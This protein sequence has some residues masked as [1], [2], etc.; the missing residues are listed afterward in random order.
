M[1]VA[2][3]TALHPMALL[4]TCTPLR[5]NT[6]PHAVTIPASLR[7]PV[8]QSGQE[9]TVCGAQLD[10]LIAGCSAQEQLFALVE[11]HGRTFSLTQSVQALSLAAKLPL[12]TPMCISTQTGVVQL[13]RLVWERLEPVGGDGRAGSACGWAEMGAQ[14]LADILCAVSELRVDDRLWML[15]AFVEAIVWW[16]SPQLPSFNCQALAD[17]A[18]A[19]AVLGI[20]TTTVTQCSWVAGS[21]QHGVGAGQPARRTTW[22]LS[23]TWALSTPHHVR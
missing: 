12:G 5:L 23:A 19:L 6:R 4:S 22:A 15:H 3:T 11:Q 10:Q 16:A 18:Q 7:R 2:H 9:L 13:L 17:T 21:V 14:D 20:A 1:L 8:M